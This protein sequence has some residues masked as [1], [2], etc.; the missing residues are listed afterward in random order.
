MIFQ[1]LDSPVPDFFPP[2]Y[3]FLILV[4]FKGKKGSKLDQKWK[5]W[6]SSASVKSWTFQRFLKQCF[7]FLEY[8]MW[9]KFWQNLAIFGGVRAKNLPKKGH[10]ID[11]ESVRKTLKIY[12]LTSKN[13]ILIKLTTI[14]YLYETFHLPKH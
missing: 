13:A 3:F 4:I 8:Y 14:M 12:Y 10:F 1:F 6:V 5:L 11:A 2:K 7:C 9:W